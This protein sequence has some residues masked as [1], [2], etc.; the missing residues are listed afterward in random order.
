MLKTQRHRQ[1]YFPFVNFF[2]YNLFVFIQNSGP[3]IAGTPAPHRICSYAIYSDQKREGQFLSPTYPG[4]YPKNLNCQY[5]FLG[6]KGQRV[7]LEF[8]DFDLFYGGPQ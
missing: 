7:R 1:I 8:M 5:R 3:F 6:R 4:V 2:D